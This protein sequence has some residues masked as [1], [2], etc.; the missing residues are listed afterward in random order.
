MATSLKS[1]LVLRCVFALFIAAALLFIPAGTLNYWQGWAYIAMFFIPMLVTSVYF[2]KR[3]PQLIERRMQMKEKVREQ[4][5]I[6]RLANLVFFGAFF[7]PGLDHRF[8]WS[9]VPLWLTVL[10]Q[11]IALAGYLM[12]FWVMQVN[13]FASR[14]IEIQPGQKVISTGPY[15]IVRHPMYLGAIVMFLFT[16]LALGSYRALPAF[17]LII[18]VIVLRLLNEEK[19]LRRELSGY[20]EYCLRTRFHLVPGIW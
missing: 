2:Y 8:G 14:I 4:K 7:I 20:P 6:I 17:A 1:R 12:S 9:H 10:S 3:D 16:P 13:S 19:V 18:P 11:V 5:V 15:R